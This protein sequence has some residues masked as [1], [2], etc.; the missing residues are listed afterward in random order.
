[1]ER[2]RDVILPD[3]VRISWASDSARQ[4]WLP[5][6]QRINDAWAQIEWLA[7]AK[8]VRACALTNV[9][10]EEFITLST[11]W[12]D[13]GLSG[14]PVELQ[15]VTQYSYS[16][17]GKS[18]EPGQPFLFRLVIGRPENISTFKKAWD[19]NRQQEMGALLGY[20]SCCTRFFQRTW[21]EDSSVDT[22]WQMAVNT[23]DGAAA[24]AETSRLAEVNGPPQANILWRW[25]GLRTVPHLPCSFHC[26]GTVA[27]GDQLMAVGREAGY[28]EEMDWLVEVL[29][30]PAEWSALHGI[31]E[32]KTPVLKVMARTDATPFKYTVQYKSDHYPEEGVQGVRFPFKV[33]ATPYV[34]ASNSYKRGLSATKRVP[35]DFP[36]WYAPDNGF[37]SRSAMDSSHLPIVELAGQILGQEGGNVLDLGCGNGALL[38]KIMAA[39]PG[40]IPFGIDLEKERI[41]HVGHLLPEFKSNFVAGNLFES[42]QLWRENY[43]YKLVLLMPGRLLEAQPDQADWLRQRLQTYC[44]VILVYAYGDW[45]ERYGNLAGLVRQAGL[46]LVNSGE[47]QRVSIARLD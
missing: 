26:T 12:A 25:M 4:V 11:H 36:D 3:F 37:A 2:M 32:I 27:L 7:V 24:E 43:R 34:S 8:G 33:P 41:E 17:T 28:E 39:A 9:S 47:D 5:R 35:D 19:A 29:S 10:P 16:S 20:P 30:W 44:D 15:S 14:F 46:R 38:K 22:T 23:L 31:A 40:V 45:L 1:M 13:N 42:D 18:A 21:V 6:I